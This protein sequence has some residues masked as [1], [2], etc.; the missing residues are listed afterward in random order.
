MRPSPLALSKASRFPLSSKQANKD[1][2]KGQCSVFFSLPQ[3]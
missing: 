2:Y 1:F 3:S